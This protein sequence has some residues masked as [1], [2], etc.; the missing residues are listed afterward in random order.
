MTYPSGHISDKE[1]FNP[2]YFLNSQPFGREM[3]ML[4]GIESFNLCWLEHDDLPGFFLTFR[5]G[6]VAQIKVSQRHV[7]VRWDANGV[8]MR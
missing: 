4:G 3:L 5:S 1:T 7:R 8:C 2:T 6:D